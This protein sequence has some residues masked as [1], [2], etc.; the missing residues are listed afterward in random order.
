MRKRI[1]AREININKRKYI[2][3]SPDGGKTIYKRQLYSSSAYTGTPYFGTSFIAGWRAGS[4][5]YDEV[6]FEGVKLDKH[7]DQLEF[8]FDNEQPQ[9]IK[10]IEDILNKLNTLEAQAREIRKSLVELE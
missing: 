8:N 2:Y 10:K 4:E 7:P 1:D 6:A 3:E 9:R 5:S